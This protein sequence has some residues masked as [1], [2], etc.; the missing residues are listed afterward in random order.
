MPTWINLIRIYNLLASGFSSARL[1]IIGLLL[2]NN[3]NTIIVIVYGIPNVK[4]CH[5]EYS[6]AFSNKLCDKILGSGV[7][8]VLELVL[9][10]LPMPFVDESNVVSAFM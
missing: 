3:I 10:A 2:G 9:C 7:G 1:K 6:S 5:S 8:S 4:K